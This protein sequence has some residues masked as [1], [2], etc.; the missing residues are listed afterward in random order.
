MDDDE[1][2]FVEYMKESDSIEDERI[3]ICQISAFRLESSK[4]A[5]SNSELALMQSGATYPSSISTTLKQLRGY[6]PFQNFN[7]LHFTVNPCI[8][9]G[10]SS[11][12]RKHLIEDINRL[13]SNYGIIDIPHSY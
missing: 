11:S 4:K 10:R 13:Y 3:Y 6:E 1:S 12:Q 2:D 7:I 5:I 8:G 9:G